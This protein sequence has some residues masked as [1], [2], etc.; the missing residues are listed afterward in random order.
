MRKEKKSA[1]GFEVNVTTRPEYARWRKSLETPSVINLLAKLAR[2][3]VDVERIRT[4]LYA[5]PLLGGFKFRHELKELD[6][7]LAVAL[8]CLQDATNL[9]AQVPGRDRRWQAAALNLLRKAIEAELRRHKQFPKVGKIDLTDWIITYLAR[10][11]SRV[12]IRDVNERIAEMLVA[13]KIPGGGREGCAWSA[14]AVKQRRT[15]FKK[16][17]LVVHRWPALFSPHPD[18]RAFFYEAMEEGFHEATRS[19]SSRDKN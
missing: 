2:R 16:N 13:A 17:P 4:L 18:P 3:D 7:R 1:L 9:L 14:E 5:A 6:Q 15:R 12:G 19:A 11:L 8:G 10:E